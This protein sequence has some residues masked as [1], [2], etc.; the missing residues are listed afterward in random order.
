[1]LNFPAFR[2]FGGGGGSNLHLE[3]SN[4]TRA[5]AHTKERAKMSFEYLISQTEL[6]KTLNRRRKVVVVKYRPSCR[7][8]WTFRWKF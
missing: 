5:R 1:M 2:Y 6:F 4:P 8:L 7:V 3:V